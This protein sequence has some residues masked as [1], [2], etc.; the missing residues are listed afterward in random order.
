MGFKAQVRVAPLDP[1][2]PTECQ[3]E[4]RLPAGPK[5]AKEVQTFQEW[6]LDRNGAGS[7]SSPLPSTPFSRGS[8]GVSR[9]LSRASLASPPGSPMANDYESQPLPFA[10]KRKMGGTTHT[11]SD[12]DGR[13]YNLQRVVVNFAN[14]GATY[15]SVVLGKDNKRGDRLFDWEGVRR[16]IKCLTQEQGLEVVGVVFENLWG[17]DRGNK[18][19]VGIPDD[20]RKMCTSIQETPRLD[21]RNHKSADD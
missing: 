18:S 3:L 11:L 9:P 20:V 21:G 16:C 13:P 10:K 4:Q 15:A 1:N 17:P 12:E 14:V 2:G 8:P 19:N 5:T 6:M 7:H